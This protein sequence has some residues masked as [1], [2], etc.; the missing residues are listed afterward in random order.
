MVLF[1]RTVYPELD[2]VPERRV[3][4]R[5]REAVLGDGP[6]DGRTAALV[7][8]AHAAGL[9]RPVFDRK[10]LRAKKARLA[11]LAEGD[12]AAEAAREAIQAVQAAVLAATAA[13]AGAHAAAT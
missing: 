5:I 9:L 11:H 2:P 10:T 13:A 6:V 3:I 1:S 7:S 8:L 4:E 12:V